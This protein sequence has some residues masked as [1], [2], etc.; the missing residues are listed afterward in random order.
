MSKPKLM[1]KPIAYYATDK[2]KR[3]P[4]MLGN[5]VRII[6]EVSHEHDRDCNQ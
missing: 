1:Q 2:V 6:M 3:I 4:S 5:R